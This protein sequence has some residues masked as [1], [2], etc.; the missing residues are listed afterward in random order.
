MSAPKSLLQDLLGFLADLHQDA[1]EMLSDDVVRNAIVADLGGDPSATTSAPQFPPAGLQSVTDYRNASEPG[2]EALFAAIQDIRAYHTALRAFVESLDLGPDAA[3]DEGFRLLLDI[4]GWNLIRLRK[5]QLYFVMQAISFVEDFTSVYGGQ[6]NGPIGLMLA[7]DRLLFTILNPCGWFEQSHFSSERGVTRISDRMAIGGLAGV[8]IF[9]LSKYA[10]ADEIFYGWDVVPGVATTTQGDLTLARTFTGKFSSTDQKKT[11]SD[12]A[13]EKNLLATLALLPRTQ[14]GPGLFASL[15]G[16]ISVD[17]EI[18]KPWHFTAEMQSAGAVSVLFSE[19]RKFEIKAPDDASDFHATVAFEA[20]PQ[21][22]TGKAIDLSFGKNLGISVEQLRIEGTLSKQAAQLRTQALGGVLSIGPKV[23]GGFI[24]KIMPKDGLRLDFDIGVGLASDRGHFLEGK[25]RS[26]GTPGT[27]KPATPAPSG[28]GV[29]PPLPPLPKTEESGPGFSLRIPLGKS[30]G[31]LTIHD[32]QLRVGME[33]PDDDRTYLIDAASSIS[34]KLGPITARVDRAGLRFGVRFPKP[35]EEPNLGWFDLDVGGLLPNGVGIAID[36]KGVVTGGGFLFYDKQQE[37]YAGVMQ[38]SIRERINVKAFGLIATKMPDGK[39]GY[40]LIVF[41]TAEGFTP[42]PI[43]MGATIRGLGGMIAINRTFD[44][45]AMREGLKNKTL[46]TLLFPKDPIRNAPEIIR[47]LVTV[48]PAEEGGFLIGFLMKVG[49]FSPTLVH[50]DLAIILETGNRM[51]VIALGMISALLP[52]RENDLVRLNM[53]AMGIINLGRMDIEID[54]VL[55]DSRLAQK[56]VLTGNMALR[57][58]PLQRSFLLSV[59]G[60]NPRFTPPLAMPKLQRITIALA[61]GNNPRLTCEA[62]FAITSN[63]VQFGARAELYAA[64]FGFSIEG[65]VG[66]DVLIQLL[67]FHLV[68]DFKASVQLKRGSRSLFKL[69]VQG[70]LEGPRPLRIAGKA[71]FEIFWCDFTIR[72]DKTLVSGEKPPL[73]PGV[74]VLAEL[75]RA[76]GAA[77]S[78]STQLAPNRQHGVTLRKLPSSTTLVLDPLGNLVVKQQLVPLNTSRELDTFG[79]SPIAGARRFG[80]KASLGVIGQDA[81]PVQDAFAPAQF[82]AMTD[83]EKLAAPSFQE[84]DAG[85]IF[86]TNAVVIDDG[87]SI[88]AP[89]DYETLVINDK[90]ELEE[91]EDYVLVPELMFQQVRFS[92]VGLAPIRSAGLARFRSI[93]APAVAMRSAQ[94]AI[95]SVEDG[96]AAPTTKAAT[97]AEAQATLT[98]LNRGASAVRWQLVPEFELAEP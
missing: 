63:T 25:V 13:F 32:L 60:F 61:S 89:L 23:L 74:D 46:P 83:D 26:F 49:W 22:E 34:T 64:A 30:L 81:R 20:R 7:L 80:V 42:I 10:P 15:G 16:G 29:P 85:V 90:G 79:G 5:P 77:D 55:V 28:P 19:E 33:G 37:L 2:L 75:K 62:Y 96:T 40:S 70:M 87:A 58:S 35:P 68:A 93:A 65:E 54:A 82:F 4:L 72:F 9:G 47:N 92:A 17:T 11:P 95:A 91:E 67:P 27:P 53:D 97:F 39:P 51:R 52:T 69:S 8:K 71:S 98:K 36:A 43:G 38:L 31:P 3:V 84:M 48:F 59:G 44:K 78:W 18:A 14:G 21:P 73:P 56:F 41:I 1:Q 50:L 57:A 86:G 76:L 66:F 88:F 45:D 24:S 12:P 94:F 6:F